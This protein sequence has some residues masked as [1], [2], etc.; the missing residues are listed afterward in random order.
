MHL[1]G[2]ET[3]DGQISSLLQPVKVKICV[4]K[5]QTGTMHFKQVQTGATQCYLKLNGKHFWLAAVIY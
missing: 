3:Y 1:L 4:K 5:K 2:R